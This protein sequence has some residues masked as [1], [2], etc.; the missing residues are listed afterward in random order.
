V[1][2]KEAP[3]GPTLLDFM[4]GGRR[5][6]EAGAEGAAKPEGARERDVAE[7]LYAY[8]KSRGRAGKDDVMQWAKARGVSAAELMRAIESL[9]SRRRLRRRLDDEGNLVYEALA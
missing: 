5:G 6:G 8:I 9:T 1:R 2:R 4:A 7:E 3:R